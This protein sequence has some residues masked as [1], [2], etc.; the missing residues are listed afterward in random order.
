MSDNFPTYRKFVGIN[1]W[2]KIESDRKFVEIKQIGSKFILHTVIAEQYPEIL[3]IADMLAC[4]D[5]RWE[6]IEASEFQR[7]FELTN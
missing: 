2:F 7:V 4:L 3:L 1:V 6:K 5:G